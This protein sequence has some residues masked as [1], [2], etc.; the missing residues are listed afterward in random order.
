[1]NRKAMESKNYRMY[2]ENLY[3][4][5]RVVQIKWVKSTASLT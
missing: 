3:E 4:V 1:M 5:E 2:N